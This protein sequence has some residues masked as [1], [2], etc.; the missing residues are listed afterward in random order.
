[1]SNTGDV[2]LY[3]VNAD[4]TTSPIALNNTVTGQIGATNFWNWSDTR[5]FQ[6]TGPITD[7]I[8]YCSNHGLTLQSYLQGNILYLH[9][10]QSCWFPRI[11]SGKS[12]SSNIL[13]RIDL[14]SRNV[15]YENTLPLRYNWSTG[16]SESADVYS[17]HES[18][19]YA[20]IYKPFFFPSKNEILVVN[21]F[22][23]DRP[24]MSFWIG[25]FAG[26]PDKLT[27][28]KSI[29]NGNTLNIGGSN[30][31]LDRIT[32]IPYDASIL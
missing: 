20:N 24:A 32:Y 10:T 9:D 30:I 29:V 3:Q 14:S 1:M 13:Y 6:K 25:K 19:Y 11:D 26:V 2:Y 21:R 18:D 27:Y 22:V 12:I 8:I 31:A 16:I 15:S 5:Y 7:Y 23:W 28:F 17:I 4:K